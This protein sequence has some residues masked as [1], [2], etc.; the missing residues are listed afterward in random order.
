MFGFWEG[1]E[2]ALQRGFK[3]EIRRLKK[4]L[5]EAQT[6]E[7]RVSL[8]ERLDVVQAQYAEINTGFGQLIF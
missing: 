6:V 8:A 7:E 2:W 4:E 5:A 3:D 1:G